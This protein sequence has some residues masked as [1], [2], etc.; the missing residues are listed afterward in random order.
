MSRFRK[1]DFFRFELLIA[2]DFTEVTSDFEVRSSIVC[3]NSCMV[4]TSHSLFLSLLELRLLIVIKHC[5]R[6]NT[7]W[8]RKTIKTASVF[9]LV[10]A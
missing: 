5:V 9:S 4:T 10:L 2:F 6:F 7:N 3:G 8:S 1:N